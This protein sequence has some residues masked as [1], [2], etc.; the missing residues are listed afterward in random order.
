MIPNMERTRKENRVHD[1]KKVSNLTGQKEKKKKKK[2]KKKNKNKK[3]NK[4]KS[5]SIQPK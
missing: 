5:R 4:T 2:T 1:S 3:Q